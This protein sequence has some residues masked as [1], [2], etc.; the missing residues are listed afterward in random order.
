MQTLDR[1]EARK[2]FGDWLRSKRTDSGLTRAA[3]ARQL[4]SLG[5][6]GVAQ[7]LRYWESGKQ[8][9]YGSLYTRLVR[10]LEPDRDQRLRI[11]AARLCVAPSELE[12]LISTD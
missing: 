4:E 1:S 5:C 12:A 9:P 10:V 3:F 8:L 6:E 7:P 11:L 2:V